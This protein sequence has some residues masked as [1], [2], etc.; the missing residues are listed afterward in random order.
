MRRCRADIPNRCCHLTSRVARRAFEGVQAANRNSRAS[1]A[2]WQTADP[3][4][5]PDGWNQLAYGMNRPTDGFDLYGGAWTT[6][7]FV[8][9]YYE[10][11]RPRDIDTD[12]IGYTEEIWSVIATIVNQQITDEVLIRLYDIAPISSG[13]DIFV[14]ET[15]RAYS[16]FVQV[17]W[18]LAGG[19]VQTHSIVYYSW[20]D[21]ERDNTLYRTY[22]ITRD[23]FYSYRDS[24]SDPLAFGEAVGVPFEIGFPVC[25]FT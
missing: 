9:Y 21:E 18:V 11:W 4:G 3:L 23:T 20:R 15:D 2:K 19:R 12:D 25:V 7:E 1:L 13:S 5:Y 10:P 22:S 24:F 8:L 17:H 16:N 14:Y 6:A